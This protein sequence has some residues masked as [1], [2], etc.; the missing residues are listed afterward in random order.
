[1]DFFSQK[2]FLTKTTSIITRASRT[3]GA[4]GSNS[5]ARNSRLQITDDRMERIILQISANNK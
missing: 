1:M 2:F 4:K 3:T 5:L